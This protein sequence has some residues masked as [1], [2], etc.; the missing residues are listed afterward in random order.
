MPFKKA[1][2]N[3]DFLKMIFYFTLKQVRTWFYL[4]KNKAKITL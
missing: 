3:S 1:K 4:L 2:T